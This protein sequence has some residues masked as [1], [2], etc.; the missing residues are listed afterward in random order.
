MYRHDI[1]LFY[2][3]ADEHILHVPTVLFLILKAGV[4]LNIEMWNFFTE[5]IVC[6]AHAIWRGKLRMADHTTDQIL[7]LK[8]SVQ[9]S[10]VEIIPCTMQR[11][12]EVCP[13]FGRNS[14]PASEKTQKERTE[15]VRH[16]YAKQGQCVIC[17]YRTTCY[18]HR[19]LP[20]HQ[21][22]DIRYLTWTRVIR[23]MVVS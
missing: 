13:Q 10:R 18:L 16:P 5:K 7:R 21:A 14:C 20:Y 8:T 22:K 1:T 12:P 3:N 17:H 6:L 2:S 9:R 15:G 23:K 19:C 4:T 11:T